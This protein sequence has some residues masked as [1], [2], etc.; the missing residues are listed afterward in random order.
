MMTTLTGRQ[1]YRT[2][3]RWLRT[4]LLVLQLEVSGIVPEFSGGTIET[5][6][7]T[8]WIDATVQHLTEMEKK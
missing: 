2:S 4:P 1:R 5:T 6:E 7:Q 3:K 8:W